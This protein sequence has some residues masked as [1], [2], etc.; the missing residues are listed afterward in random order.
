M[1]FIHKKDSFFLLGLDIHIEGFKKVIKRH[2]HIKFSNVGFYCIIE[3]MEK[4]A[5]IFYYNKSCIKAYFL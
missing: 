5:E 2:A 3:C 1:L 4:A